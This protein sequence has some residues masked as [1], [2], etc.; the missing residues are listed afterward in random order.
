MTQ[1]GKR[2]DEG[3]RRHRLGDWELGHD[4]V[5]A[6]LVPNDCDL[7]RGALPLHST[8]TDGVGLPAL[9]RG[10][11]L[12]LPSRF[13]TGARVGGPYFWRA[14]GKSPRESRK[15]RGTR[16][17]KGYACMTSPRASIVSPESALRNALNAMPNP[18]C[19]GTL[20]APRMHAGRGEIPDASCPTVRCLPE[21][22]AAPTSGGGEKGGGGRSLPV[23]LFSSSER[24]TDL[25]IAHPPNTRQTTARRREPP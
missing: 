3:R 13:H 12:R 15:P 5:R 10:A 16:R 25:R 23:V 1:T 6:L 7:S 14:A 2:S 24:A 17:G 20:R 4:A 8:R 19:G 21:K 18:A 22:Q 9:R 11:R